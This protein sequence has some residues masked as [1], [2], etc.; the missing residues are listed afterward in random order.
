M[1]IGWYHPTNSTPDFFHECADPSGYDLPT[2]DSLYAFDGEGMLQLT[3]R[4]NGIINTR[5]YSAIGLSTALSHGE[6]YN[7]T[8]KLHL[9]LFGITSVGSFGAYFAS[10]S[11]I[12]QSINHSLYPLN[13]QLQR[14][15]YSMMSDFESWYVWSDTLIA[16]GG[17]QFLIL[18]NFLNDSLTPFNQIG[19]QPSSAYFIDDI[20]LVLIEDTLASTQEMELPKLQLTSNVVRDELRFSVSGKSQPNRVTIYSLNGAL[21]EQRPYNGAN[22]IGVSHLPAGM[23]VISATAKN[24]LVARERFVKL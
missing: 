3:V 9:A 14:N 12:D 24:G 13:P 21:L 1:Q 10:D 4:G 11:S 16:Q 8:L 20:S 19:T 17:E 6:H 7:L 15:P 22:A 18:G 23:Y 2:Q 5:E